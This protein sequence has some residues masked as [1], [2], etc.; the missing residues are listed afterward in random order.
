MHCMQARDRQSRQYG[1]QHAKNKVRGGSGRTGAGAVEREG[2]VGTVGGLV[3]LVAVIV[4]SR[5]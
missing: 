3:C 2:E 5:S 1:A 4:R